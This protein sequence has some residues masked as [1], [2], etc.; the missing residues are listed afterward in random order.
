MW[1]IQDFFKNSPSFGSIFYKFPHY[2]QN[3]TGLQFSLQKAYFF[4]ILVQLTK[5]FSGPV[6]SGT[7]LRNL[8]WTSRA[9]F[10][11][12]REDNLSDWAP[13]MFNTPD[14]E[15]KLVNSNIIRKSKKLSLNLIKNHK[16]HFLLHDLRNMRVLLMTSK[17]PK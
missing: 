7:F 9:Q 13:Y 4:S 2:P 17:N 1:I 12:F 10:Q 8:A 14:L 5:F 11:I 15:Q 16:N 3:Y 6:R